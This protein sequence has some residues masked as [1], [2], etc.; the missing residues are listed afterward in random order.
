[1]SRYA[2]GE[3]ASMA[4]SQALAAPLVGG[5]VAGEQTVA[6]ASPGHLVMG[7]HAFTLAALQVRSALALACRSM[8]GCSTL[9]TTDFD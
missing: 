6:K 1:M 5:E 2:N 8:M 7:C 9:H 4:P 3:G